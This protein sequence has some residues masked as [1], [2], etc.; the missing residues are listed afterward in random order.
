MR[1]PRPTATTKSADEIGADGIFCLGRLNP[2]GFACG[3]ALQDP[4]HVVAQVAHDLHALFVQGG[5]F[6]VAAVYHRP[7]GGA[8]Q[9]HLA[10]LGNLFQGFQCAGG[11]GAAGAGN[12]SGGLLCQQA[13]CAV[14]QPVHEAQHAGS[15][16]T[17]TT[18]PPNTQCPALA[19]PPQP[20]QPP[21]GTAP[22]W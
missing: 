5:L 21:T 8:D 2:C 1:A 6:G 20:T 11:A 12:N 19:Q 13:A 7:V 17:S 14:A 22:M 4:G 16:R 18:G 9:R 10:E 15:G 3:N